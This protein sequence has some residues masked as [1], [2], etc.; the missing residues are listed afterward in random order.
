MRT[1][2]IPVFVGVF[3]GGALAAQDAQINA[4]DAFFSAA[5]MVAVNKQGQSKGQ[6]SARAASPAPAK[7]STGGTK[8]DSTRVSGPRPEFA[9]APSVKD[10]E[11]HFQFVSQKQSQAPPL[12]LRYSILKKTSSGLAEVRSD[13]EFKAGDSIRLSVMG[14]QKGYLY[15]IARGA[16]GIWAPLFPHP[17]S[18]QQSNE[19]VPGR[20]YQVPGGAGE[21]FTFDEQAGEEKL[22]VLL[23]TRPVQDIE[24]LIQSVSGKG[25]ALP[26]RPA[27]AGRPATMQAKNSFDDRW[28]DQLRLQVQSRDLVFTKVDKEAASSAEKSAPGVEAEQAT[29]VVNTASLSGTGTG[30]R[31]VVDLT[32]RH[33]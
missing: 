26:D 17:E 13:S 16:S 24:E 6:K 22:F 30:G 5:D 19:I 18:S 27:A 10:A 8:P 21:Y 7:P 15:V 14:N 28:I 11:S 4:R 3:L 2:L 20:Q 23:S 12:G 31:V 33:K 29:Y 1:N 9:S 32:L 25:T